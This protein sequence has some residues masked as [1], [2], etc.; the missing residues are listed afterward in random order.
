M[1]VIARHKI[2]VIMLFSV[3]AGS[4]KKDPV[5]RSDLWHPIGVNETNIAAMVA[6]PGDLIRGVEEPN[7][8]GVRAAAAVRR[9]ETDH[10]KALPDSGL[11]EIEV[12]ANGGGQGTAGAAGGGGT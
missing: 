2:P 6:S 3:V 1:A 11:S 4:K 7:A 12:K 10:V 5:L 9:L 8:D